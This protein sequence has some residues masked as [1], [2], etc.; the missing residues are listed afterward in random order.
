M[1]GIAASIRDRLSQQLRESQFVIE[2]PKHKQPGIGR[3]IFFNR[4]PFD[5]FSTP[6]GTL[7]MHQ[8]SVYSS[9]TSL[10][11]RKLNSIN[12]FY[13]AMATIFESTVNN[14]G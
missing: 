6:I 9:S 11:F 2:R 13:A 8:Q 7:K 14:P 5:R 10:C 4:F 12:N 3:E 1:P